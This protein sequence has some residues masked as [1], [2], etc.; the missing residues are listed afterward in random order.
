MSDR[1]SILVVD[2][3]PLNQELISAYLSHLDCDV[4]LASNGTEAM[5]AVERSKP[6][7]VLLDVMMPGMNGYEI[8]QQ[9]KSRDDTRDV[10]VLL[11]TALSDADHRAR[12]AAAGADDFIVK[13]VSREELVE[14][15]LNAIGPPPESQ[16]HPP[17]DSV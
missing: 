11:L 4:E 17:A 1:P 12:G 14:R 3:A 6:V 5:A 13:P 7:L 10:P 15:V 16:E 8:C 9:L 2:D